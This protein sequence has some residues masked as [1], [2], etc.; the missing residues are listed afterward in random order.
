MNPGYQELVKLLKRVV[1]NVDGEALVQAVD[2]HRPAFKGVK[3]VSVTLAAAAFVDA[4]HPVEEAIDLAVKELDR[5]LKA[6]ID[7]SKL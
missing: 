1:P 5:R 7:A 2:A 3:C 4:G 6:V